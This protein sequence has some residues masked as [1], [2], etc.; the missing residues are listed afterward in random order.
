MTHT[1]QFRHHDAIAHRGVDDAR[2]RLEHVLRSRMSEPFA[3]GHNDCALFAAACVEA[4]TGVD[5]AA[6]WVG[7]WSTEKEALRLIEQLG[8]M[9]AIGAMVG[10]EVPP[11][12]AQVGDI[13]LIVTGGR[14]SLAVCNGGHWLA[15]GAQGLGVVELTAAV[16][17]W[18]VG[19]G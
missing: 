6:Q 2:A 7:Q 19:R 4:Q 18:R 9:G 1:T 8:G 14:E 10:D 13:G 5:L 11:L 3:W 12:C 16:R 17:A 15:V